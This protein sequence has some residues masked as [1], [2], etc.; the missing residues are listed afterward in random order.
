MFDYAKRLQLA[1]ADTA[2]RTGIKA[3]AGAILCLAAGFLLAALWSFLAND[4]GWGSTYAS[5]TIGGVFA[6]IA[7]ALWL[8]AAK[9]RHQ[10]PTNDDLKREVEARINLAADAAADRAR[11]EAMRVMDMAENKIYSAMDTASYRANKMADDAERRVHGFMRDTVQGSGR[12]RP[13]GPDG[14]RQGSGG[15]TAKM[16]AALALGLTVAAKMRGRRQRPPDDDEFM[17]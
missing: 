4:L 17:L 1:L 7:G 2:R 11:A 14:A 3:A 15:N 5:L 9:P 12:S 8:I 6:V 13:D 10:M 16:V